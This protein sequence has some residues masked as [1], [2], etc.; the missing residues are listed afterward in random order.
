MFMSHGTSLPETLFGKAFAV[1]WNGPTEKCE[2][3]YGITFNFSQYDIIDN[4]H[5]IFQGDKMVIFYNNQ[6]GLYP[7]IMQNGN[8]INGGIPQKTNLKEHLKQEKEDVKA[9]IS[10]MN[11]TGPAVIDWENWRPLFQRNFGNKRIYQS[12]SRK[13]VKRQHPTWNRSQINREA[14]IEFERAARELMESTLNLGEKLRNGARWGFYGFPRIYRKHLNKTRIDNDRLDWLFSSST[15]LY[16]SIYLHSKY[17]SWQKKYNFVTNTLNETFR[18]Y[19]K[20]CL[21]NKTIVVPYARFRYTKPEVFYVKNELMLS[22]LLPATIGS[23]GVV[24]W[25]SS[26]D[27]RNQRH[28]QLMKNYLTTTLGPFVKRLT[29]T[30]QFCSESLCNG[31][32]LI[33]VHVDDVVTVFEVQGYSGK[34]RNLYEDIA[35]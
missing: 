4:T 1:I 27:F 34:V 12:A 8:V 14:K 28:C 3:K 26:L 2:T 10:A 33:I 32:L 25:D 11:F 29:E 9:T 30:F 13:L 5:D 19:D 21:R 15:G 22:L 17:D 20:F 18:I 6:L 24:L 35:D 16:P 7:Y 31:I 23:A